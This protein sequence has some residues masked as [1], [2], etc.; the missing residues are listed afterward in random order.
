MN[1]TTDYLEMGGPNA[2][3]AVKVCNQTFSA[4]SSV[5]AAF[6]A[7]LSVLDD[8][9]AL[10]ISVNDRIGA[11]EKEQAKLQASAVFRE[12]IEVFRECV[13][14]EMGQASWRKLSSELYLE[15]F[16]PPKVQLVRHDT[17]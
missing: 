6:P 16:K 4:T 13:A 14:E 2:D 1:S 12:P 3:Q 17:T 11:L 15:N 10:A 7:A 8:S 5:E 9:L